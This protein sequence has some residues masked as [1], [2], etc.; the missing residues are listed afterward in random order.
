MSDEAVR[1]GPPVA[2]ESYLDM[3]AVFNAIET[4][5]AQAVSFSTCT[6]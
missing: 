6:L 1:I 3:A 5:G 2:A 4:T